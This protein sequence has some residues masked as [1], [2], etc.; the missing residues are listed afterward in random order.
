MVRNVSYKPGIYK[1]AFLH[2]TAEASCKD[3]VPLSGMQGF[4][5]LGVLFSSVT[6]T[7]MFNVRV[8]SGCN[9]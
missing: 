5:L 9:P 4:V 1:L 3:T 6:A 8:F 2:A 7:G